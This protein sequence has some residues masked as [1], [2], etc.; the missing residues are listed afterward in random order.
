MCWQTLQPLLCVR[1]T[2]PNL[3]SDCPIPGTKKCQ[4][5]PAGVPMRGNYKSQNVETLPAVRRSRLCD[6]CWLARYDIQRQQAKQ[7]MQWGQQGQQV[8]G[9]GPGQSGQQQTQ[10]AQWDQQGQQWQITIDDGH[11]ITDARMPFFIVDYNPSVMAQHDRSQ[12][13]R[14]E[15]QQ[16]GY[17]GGQG[18]GGNAGDWGARRGGISGPSENGGGR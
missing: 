9:G 18:E 11:V 4:R 14:P 6:G 3:T 17:A 15:C 1:P 10:W 2:C 5:S 13:D 12:C 16:Q 8:Q 7:Q